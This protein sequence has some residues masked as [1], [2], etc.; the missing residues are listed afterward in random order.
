M[1]GL[2]RSI[3]HLCGTI[4]FWYAGRIIE[5]FGSRT[6]LIGETA[7][8]TL[9][10]FFALIFPSVLSPFMMALTNLTY[11]LSS[12]ARNTL[13]QREFTDSQRSTMDSMVSLGGSLLFTVVAVLLGY[14]ADIT[15]P[16]HAMLLGLS[17]NVIILW[18][19][20]LMF[21]NNQKAP[22]DSP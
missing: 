15:S 22:S 6:V 5:R 3:N 4:S 14:I 10:R 8:T 19:Y 21:Q 18:I 12:T 17:S 2:V 16:I 11:G 13:M 1:I 9:A 7:V 20:K